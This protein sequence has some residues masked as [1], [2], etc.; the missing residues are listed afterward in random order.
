MI[1]FGGSTATDIEIVGAALRPLTMY[2]NRQL[3]K[4]LEDLGVPCEAFMRLQADA[5]E[6]LRMTTKSDVNAA[7][8]LERNLIGTAARLPW[9]MK[10]LWAIGFSAFDDYFLRNTVELSLLIQLREIKHRTRIRVGNGHTLYGLAAT[11]EFGI[12]DH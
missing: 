8:F 3:V 5:V 10:K 1:K 7:S 2:L 12:I 4:I 11:F 6:E 9:L